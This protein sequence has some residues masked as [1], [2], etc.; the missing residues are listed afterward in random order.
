MH[1][2]T[3][4]QP[5]QPLEPGNRRV[6]TKRECRAQEWNQKPLAELHNNTHSSNRLN[7][8]Q[9]FFYATQIYNNR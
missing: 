1:K 6:D 3:A 9:C 7:V 8:A 4:D 2:Y 5:K